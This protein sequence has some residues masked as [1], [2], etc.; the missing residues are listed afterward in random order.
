MPDIRVD[1]TAESWDLAIKEVEKYKRKVKALDKRVVKRMAKDGVKTAREEVPVYTG[2]LMEAIEAIVEKNEA[3]VMANSPY[4]EFVEFGT[5]MVGANNPHPNP[6]G[7]AYD[8]NGH[9]EEG[10]IWPGRDGRFHW[11]MGQPAK[12]FMYDTAQILAKEV[13]DVVREE[14]QS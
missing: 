5:G 11:T 12:P 9:G 1:L 3:I 14:L 13:P 4:A 2:A 10:W 7:W 6:V 8:I